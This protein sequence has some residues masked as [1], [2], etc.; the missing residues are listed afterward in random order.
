MHNN[1]ELIKLTI[2]KAKI[3]LKT[4]EENIKSKHLEGALNRIYYA[5]FY[6]VNALAIKN[7]FSTSNHSQLKGWFNKK[8]IYE[9]KIFNNKMYEIYKNVYLIREKS[10]YDFAYRPDLVTVKIML[11]DAKFFIK[12][13]INK[14]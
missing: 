12:N 2:E 6:S 13:I 1:K 14:L 4:A 5:V 3:A 11:N 8:F 9:K 10:D 7:N